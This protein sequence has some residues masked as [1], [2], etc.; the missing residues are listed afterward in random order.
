VK[1]M[2]LIHSAGTETTDAADQCTVED[3]VAYDK[4]IREAGIW[5][6]RRCGSARTAAER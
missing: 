5:V 6:S 3:W 4:E 2:L 1:Y